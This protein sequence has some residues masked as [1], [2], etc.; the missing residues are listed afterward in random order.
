MQCKSGGFFRHV[1]VFPNDV[2]LILPK[3]VER[4][5]LGS[6]VFWTPDFVIF[7]YGKVA[8]SKMIGGMEMSR[9]STE[10]IVCPKCGEESEFIMWSSVNTMLNPELKEKVR[11]NELFTFTC[12]S[13][14]NTATVHYACL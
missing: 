10:L 11:N 1:L 9:Y 13:C 3:A 8:D 12:P 5:K 2:S 14:G 4:H 6:P 7:V